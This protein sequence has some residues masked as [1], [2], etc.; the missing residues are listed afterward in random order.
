MTE[1]RGDKEGPGIDPQSNVPASGGAPYNAESFAQM[2]VT[3]VWDR[4]AGRL[5]W[6]RGQCLALLDDGCDL[7]VPEWQAEG[8]WVWSRH[9]ARKG[10]SRSGHWT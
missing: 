5:S 2:R 7:T 8:P 10:G 4:Y 3:E 9:T 6:G 1:E